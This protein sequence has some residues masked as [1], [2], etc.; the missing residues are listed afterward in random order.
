[1]SA[2]LGS[3]SPLP[4]SRWRWPLTALFVLLLA[5][6]S[7]YRETAI[8]M[9]MI[10]NRSETFAHCFLVPP[11]SLWLMWRNRAR[12]QTITPAAQPWMLGAV[13]AMAFMWL[14]SDMAG[15]NAAA[16][17]AFTAL[18]VLS[19][20]AVLGLQ[21]ARAFAF[22]L[23]FLFFMVPVG[24][25]L[26]PQF[27]DWTADFTVLAIRL[28]GIP[29]YREGLNFVIPSGSWSVVEA[30]S[31][32]RYMIASF[33]VGS[34]FA[35]LNYTSLRRRLIFCF[36]SLLVPLVANWLRAYMIVMLGHVSG[37]TLAVGVDH[38]IYGWVFFGIVIGGM[39][40]VGARWAE[41][42][43]PTAGSAPAAQPAARK[44]V[45]GIGLTSAVAGMILLAPHLITAHFEQQG[46]EGVDA[47]LSLGELPG[48]TAATATGV[49]EP[50]FLN[51]STTALRSYGFDGQ[52]VTVHVGYYRHQ[53]YGRKLVSSQN[54][55]VSSDDKRWRRVAQG[56]ST[57]GVAGQS[58]VWRSAEVVEGQV[59]TASV[60]SQRLDVRQ[61]FWVDNRLTASNAR[62]TLYALAAK[63]TGR[64]D[65][66]ALITI[67]TAG[68]N[69]AE[70][71]A[72][73]ARFIDQHGAA[74][75]AQLQAYRSLH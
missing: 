27:M 68:E 8:A 47:P 23:L 55:L 39:F 49:L 25:F 63:L 10:W 44:G 31:G 40:L 53:G 5:L 3:A 65:D 42:P 9:V 19:V 51:P 26:M 59:G 24:E 20:P 34:L 71:A 15:V 69:P 21:V 18:L 22:P 7:L 64:G 30:C 43:A 1:V 12:L 72:R 54:Y 66:G 61:I 56:A 35:Y 33:M 74:L 14:L 13:A 16:Q 58:L 70:T 6:L 60:R 67:Y 4:A 28:T 41:P 52:V 46:R 48:T 62:A 50:V 45:V 57:H 37:N 29:V 17:F 75:Q 11:I 38:L 32:I 2:V 36:V 73:L